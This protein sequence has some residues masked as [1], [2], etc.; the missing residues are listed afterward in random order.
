MLFYSLTPSQI[1]TAGQLIGHY[2]SPSSHAA[3]LPTIWLLLNQS[4]QEASATQTGP[5]DL[6][7]ATLDHAI[8]VSS[9]SAVKPLATEFVGRL[10]L[11]RA[12]LGQN[13][14]IVFSDSGFRSKLMHSS[15]VN[16]EYLGDPRI[17]NDLK[18]GL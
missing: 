11:V 18:N 3:L 5:S 1:T 9:V 14:P 6:L 15:V 2:L 10:L 16:S 12:F 4:S 13:V 7:H 17:D 8:K